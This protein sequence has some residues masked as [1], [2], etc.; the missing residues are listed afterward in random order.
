M[1]RWHYKILTKQIVIRIY[2]SF[3]SL[4]LIIIGS[5]L[6]ALCFLKMEDI[7]LK[8]EVYFT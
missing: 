2:K 7:L 1:L 4:Q 5:M 3:D 8:T 6:F